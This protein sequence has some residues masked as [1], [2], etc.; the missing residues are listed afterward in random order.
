MGG[1]EWASP[2]VASLLRVNSAKP[3]WG[4]AE[5]VPT[6]TPAYQARRGHAA[7]SPELR[8]RPMPC[9]AAAARKVLRLR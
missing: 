3:L 7:Q 6:S 1:V 4:F 9:I 8:A 2:F 5:R